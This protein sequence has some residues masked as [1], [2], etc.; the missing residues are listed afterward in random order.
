LSRDA[1]GR[2]TVVTPVY[3]GEA[4]IAECIESVLAQTHRDWTH[5]VVDNCSTDATPEI[6]ERYARAD[7]RVRLER[8]EVFVKA[9]ENHNRAFAALEP[10]AAFCKV[11]Q[12]DDWLYPECLERMVAV[13]GSHP[14]VGMVTAYRLVDTEVDLDGTP[15]FV[16]ALPGRAVLRQSL[17]GGPYVTGS[18]TSI[19]LRAS[20]VRG[21]SPFYDLDFLHTDTEAAYYVM[22]R[23]DVGFVHQVLTFSRRQEGSRITFS[24]R[25]KT[26]APENIRMLLRY[27]PGTLTA[28][29]LEAQLRRELRRYGFF[30][31]KQ[32]LKP[33]RLRDA[34]FQAFHRRQLAKIEADPASGDSVQRA[35]KAL[36][37]VLN[38]GEDQLVDAS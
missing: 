34:E 15:Y 16:S 18:P 17:L 14:E 9:N 30:L 28:A 11:V 8:H 1:D 20:V 27:G 25:V 5:V 23:S 24:D 38:P 10:E 6:V 7:S 19:L 33:S 31:A 35:A 29:E 13:A 21:R 12:G 4:T 37:L 32:R 26:Y 2:I 36:R 3:N 22:S